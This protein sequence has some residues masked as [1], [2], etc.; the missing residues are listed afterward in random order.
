[1]DVLLQSREAFIKHYEAGSFPFRLPPY[2]ELS[3]ICMPSLSIQIT[4]LAS[5]YLCLRHNH[6]FLQ[7]L[8][9]LTY[10]YNSCVS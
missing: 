10:L 8:C 6:T 1:M 9:Q 2:F 7:I 5:V 3:F 4:K